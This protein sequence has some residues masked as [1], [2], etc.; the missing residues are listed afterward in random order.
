MAVSSLYLGVDVGGT[1]TDAVVLSGDKVTGWAKTATTKDITSGITMAIMGALQDMKSQG[2]QGQISQVNI[3]TTHFLN[4]V[5]QRKNLAK[6]SV[7]RLCGPAS[8]SLPPCIDIPSDLSKVICASTHLLQGGYEYDG[9]EITSVDVQEVKS[10]IQLLKEQ[11]IRNVV[12]C[13]I[14]SPVNPTQEL[15]VASIFKEEYPDVSLTLSHTIS[16]IGL[17]ERESAAILNESLK[18]LCL[19]TISAFQTALQQLGLDCPFYLTQNNGTILSAKHV[20]EFPVRTFSSGPTNSMRGAAHLSGVKDAIV[21]DIGGTSTDVGCLNKG[22]PRL[23]STHVELG[24]VRTNFRMPDVL[25]IGLGGGSHVNMVQS[26]NGKKSVKVGPLSCG[27]NL[28]VQGMVFGEPVGEKVLT[29]TDIAVAAGLVNLGDPSKVAHLDKQLIDSAVEEMHFM[30]ESAI[31]KVKLKSMDQPI[32]LVGGGSI[33]VDERRQLQGVSTVIKPPHFEVANAVGAAL[34]QVSGE[35][36]VV[37]R[38][39]KAVQDMLNE[40]STDDEIK[41]AKEIARQHAIDAAKKKAIQEAVNAGADEST[42]EIT[43]FEE[44]P[45]TYL[46]GNAVRYK[47]QAIGSLK[48]TDQQCHSATVDVV[49]KQPEKDEAPQEVLQSQACDLF[50]VG[51]APAPSEEASVTVEPLAAKDNAS[52]DPHID[53]VTGEWLLSERDIDCISIGATILGCGGGGNPYFLKLQ[54]K[55]QIQDGKRIRVITPERINDNGIVSCIA[56]MGAPMITIEKLTCDSELVGSVLCMQNIL[57]SGYSDGYIQDEDGI[58]VKEIDGLRYIDDYHS[59]CTSVMKPDATNTLTA[60]MSAEIGGLNSMAPLYV[61]SVLDI[62]VVDADGMGRAFPELQM[63]VPNICGLPMHPCCLSDE[64]GRR[65]VVLKANTA[66]DI[67]DYMRKVVVEMGCKGALSCCTFNKEDIMSHSVKYSISRAWR[68][69]QAVIHA[70]S[71]KA[72]PIQAI[73]K[74]ENGKLLINGKVLACVPDLITIIDTDT[75]ECIPTDEV[76]YGLRVTVLVL[77]SAHV[78]R[79]PTAL[80]VIGPQAFGYSEEVQYHPVCDSSAYDP[81]PP[82]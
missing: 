19:Q 42:I 69:G 71:I 81:I 29:A 9:R 66:K 17:L 41:K 8:T 60:L 35:K 11:G 38:M 39:D 20:L 4:A 58:N 7:I 56:Y 30:V 57:K 80:E 59:D 49:V 3:G 79:T 67:E 6:V 78:L 2:H 22:L 26:N 76:R 24:G 47:V 62:P 53:T 43:D 48:L 12:V 75:G 74:C 54:T 16:Q 28:T 77:P 45:L 51:N 27:N 61:G 25:C 15:K 10:C 18:P 52:D 73:L 32:I 46:T 44:I 33:L 82:M 50:K 5:I 14:F 13:G 72:D 1:N 70:K 23:A 40:N 36:D 65:A 63:F 68:L 34:S 21:L 31:D 64:K 55:R 37:V